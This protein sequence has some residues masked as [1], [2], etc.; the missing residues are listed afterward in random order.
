MAEEKHKGKK[1]LS[2][3]DKKMDRMLERL[4]EECEKKKI[5]LITR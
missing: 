5:P 4:A 1:S 2:E 3:K